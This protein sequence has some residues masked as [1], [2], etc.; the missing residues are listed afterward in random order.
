MTRT[1]RPGRA[2]IAVALAALVMNLFVGTTTGLARLGTPKE[3][4]NVTKARATTA[5]VSPAILRNLNKARQGEVVQLQQDGWDGEAGLNLVIAGGGAKY[6]YGVRLTVPAATGPVTIQQV[7]ALILPDNDGAGLNAGEAIEWFVFV[8]A[9]GSGIFANAALV[10]RQLDVV[11]DPAQS[12]TYDFSS[13]IT[14]KQ[15]DIYVAVADRST[16]AEATTIPYYSTDQ[17]AT[18]E[19]RSYY[20]RNPSGFSAGSTYAFL[21]SIEFSDG[22]HPEGN[23]IMRL[24]G[25]EAGPNDPATGGDE[26][27]NAAL[28]TPTGLTA[29]AAGSLTTL[30]WTAAQPPAPIAETEP[31]NNGANANPAEPNQW[32]AGSGEIDDPGFEGPVDGDDLEDVYRFAHTG[33]TINISLTIGNPDADWDLYVF[34]DDGNVGPADLVGSSTNAA[35]ND[36]LVEL[37]GPAGNYLIGVSDWDSPQ[38]PAG[39]EVTTY[40]LS[41]GNS[42]QIVRYNIFCG[43]GPNVV[44]GPATFYGTAG[45]TATSFQVQNP[46]Q[47]TAYV[48]TA[49]SGASQSN[50]SNTASGDAPCEGGPAV[51]SHVL[52]LKKKGKLT[53]N[54]AGYVAGMTVLINNVQANA[55]QVK[56]QGARLVLKGPLSTGQKFS[57]VIP[58]GS[59]FTVVIVAPSGCTRYTATA[60]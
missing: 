24:L 29:T 51:N 17:G 31:N 56:K 39:G 22:S 9:S 25:V 10:H 41:I 16:D 38:N 52:S 12:L 40:V 23:I 36:E 20:N 47:G 6:G 3:Q 18:N 19:H 2:T 5:H 34:R 15:G 27:V 13:P 42:P 54:G 14:V 28:S 60:P 1:R 50:P 37:D 48:V 30:S 26:S 33:G 58:A 35:G 43:P 46:A 4:S 49:V 53:L 11:K 55:G 44:P 45:G 32:Y 7:I 57:D 59:Q 21:D 8:D